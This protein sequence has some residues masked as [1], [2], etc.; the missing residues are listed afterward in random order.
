MVVELLQLVRVEQKISCFKLKKLPK[1][2]Y[3][4]TSYGI[5]FET[6]V[7]H[8]SKAYLLFKHRFKLKSPKM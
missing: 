3:F 6:V 8:F 4:R 2:W 7:E 5:V 1:S